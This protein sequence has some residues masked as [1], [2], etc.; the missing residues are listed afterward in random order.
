[1]LMWILL[2]L[3]AAFC[4]LTVLSAL[5]AGSE[6]EDVESCEEDDD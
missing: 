2:G 3:F 4:A 1:M 5:R 6:I